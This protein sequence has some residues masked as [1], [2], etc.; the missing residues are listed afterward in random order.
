MKEWKKRKKRVKLSKKAKEDFDA[1]RKAYPGTKRGLTAGRKSNHPSSNS[2]LVIRGD[3]QQC[4]CLS[5]RR[6]K[7][8]VLSLKWYN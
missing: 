4:P 2:L 8:R 1:F 6:A 5:V 7:F 3:I